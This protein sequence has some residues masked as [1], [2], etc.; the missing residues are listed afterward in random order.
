MSMATE[1]LPPPRE[2]SPLGWLVGWYLLLLSGCIAAGWIALDR[3]DEPWSD[4]VF[5]GAIFGV[6][7]VLTTGPICL[8]LATRTLNA[9]RNREIHRMI[10]A[11][12]EHAM[13]SDSAKRI[14]HRERELSLI[15]NLIEQDISDGR[16]GAALRLVDELAEKFGWLEEAETYRSHI[17]QARRNEVEH[18]LADGLREVNACIGANQWNEASLVGKR[19]QRLFP[20]A[21]GLA[22]LETHIANARRRQAASLA[23]SLDTA[24]SEDRIEEAM[25][26]L[27]ELDLHVDPDEAGRLAPIAEEVIGRHRESL[28]QRYRHAVDAHRWSEAVNIG[29][30]ITRDYPNTKMAEEAKSMLEGLRQRALDPQDE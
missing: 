29:E 28:G 7:V 24:R 23:Q 1:Q 8:L 16:F 12:H 9:R 27:R 25:E 19:L 30:Q 18:Q 10:E 5:Q 17:D 21:P 3:P 11:M 13:L 2:G 14:V 22:D 20:D 4:H 6:A 15:R 26:I